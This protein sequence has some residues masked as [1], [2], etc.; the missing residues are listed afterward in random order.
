MGSSAVPLYVALIAAI[1]TVLAASL[2][3]ARDRRGERE[4][5][6]EDIQILNKFSEKD[7]VISAELKS[8]IVDRIL[9]LTCETAIGES[10]RSQIYF[11]SM[12]VPLFGVLAW[13][14]ANGFRNWQ[15]SVLAAIWIGG[16]TLAT[17]V[18]RRRRHKIVDKKLE[19]FGKLPLHP[20]HH[21]STAFWRR[22]GN[23]SD[24]KREEN[25]V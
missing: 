20:A 5:I 21:W 18:F 4:R 14:A 24:S 6:L 19:D 23:E 10:D 8:H 7:W 22:R 15:L 2:S 16:V 9:K 3:A 25:N 11:T 13:T 17:Y 12:S 1:A